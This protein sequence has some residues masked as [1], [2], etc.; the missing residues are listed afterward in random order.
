MRRSL[1]PCLA[2][3]AMAAP[4][5]SQDAAPG[6]NPIIRDKFTADPAPMVDGERLYLYVGHDEAQRDEM[7]NMKEWLVYSTTD[8]RHWTD[9]GPIMKVSDFKW[10]KKDAWAAQA[11]RKNGRY[12][13]YAAVEHDQ[14]HP[15]KAI[16]V[17][18]SD[19]PTGPFVDAKGSA[20][21]TNQMTPKG[22]HSW[23]DIDPTVFTDDDGTTWIAWG[24]R[25]AYI[26]KLK[27]NMIELDGPIREITPPHFEEGPWLHKRGKF[28]YLTYASLDRA[29][30]RDERISYATATSLDGP[31]TYRGELTGSGKYSFTIHPGIAQYKGDW[32]IF[33]HN[34]SLAIGDLNGAIG[35]RAVTVERLEYNSDGTLKPVV[36]TEAGI[37]APRAQN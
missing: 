25:Q 8:M 6:S 16:A 4:A 37:T 28:Y 17:A 24:N 5:L 34:A 9:H 23:E 31:W 36:Q 15:G 7:F 3:A 18:V 30:H 13:F 14:T 1:F 12:W 26:A 35:R 22:T 11:I 33:L 27:S 21:I 10:A 29:T 32:Y 2:L 19:K 20:L